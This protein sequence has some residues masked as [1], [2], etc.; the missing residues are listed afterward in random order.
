MVIIDKNS[1]NQIIGITGPIGSGKSYIS[2]LF[3][4]TGFKIIDSDKVYHSL[5]SKKTPL[6]EALGNEFGR[7]VLNPDGSLNR[8]ALAKLVFN[9][10]SKL[11]RLNNLTHSAV[12]D[13]ILKKCQNYFEKGNQTVIVEVPLMFESGFDKYCSNVI[14]VVASEQNRC[15]R[16]MKRNGFSEEEALKRIKKQK[17]NDFYI[18]KS[19]KIVYNNSY[20]VARK[21]F[22]RILT[23]LFE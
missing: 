19:N 16:I 20:V 10:D 13:A 17:N 6:T 15:K 3:K 7:S 2:Y 1:Q 8:P 22:L 12:I 9:D 18:E 11:Q 5:T 4:K 14:C 21:D 23:E